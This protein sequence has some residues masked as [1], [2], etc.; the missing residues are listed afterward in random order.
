MWRLSSA[1]NKLECLF[2]ASY[3]YLLKAISSSYLM[4]NRK[5]KKPIIVICTKNFMCIGSFDPYNSSVRQKLLSFSFYNSSVRWIFLLFPIYKC[6]LS[7]R[8]CQLA[9]LFYLNVFLY[10]CPFH[11]HTIAYL[12]RTCPSYPFV[13]TLGLGFQYIYSK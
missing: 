1:M 3:F 12:L 6:P 11:S 2:L 7:H 4:R 13:Q 8:L 10:T 5:K 9:G